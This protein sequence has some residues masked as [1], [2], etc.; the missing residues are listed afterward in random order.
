MRGVPQFIED[1]FPF[2]VVLFVFASCAT[3]SGL[4]I[5]ARPGEREGRVLTVATF[6][7]VHF[8]SYVPLIEKFEREHP[9]LRVELELVESRSLFQRIFA[10][11]MSDIPG[12]DVVEIEIGSVGRFFSGPLEEVGFVDL[13]DRLHESGLYDEFVP[14]KFQAWTSRGR[15]FGLPRDVSPVALIYQNQVFSRAGVDPDSIETWDDFFEAGQRLTQ[16]VD[17]DGVID[18]YAIELSDT[19]AQD[20]HILLLQRGGDFFLPDLQLRLEEE[21]VVDTLAFYLRM[22]AGPRRIGAPLPNQVAANQAVLDGYVLSHL[23]PDWKLGG[24]RHDSPA[25]AGKLRVM[26]L[27]AWERGGRRT[28]TYGGTMMSICKSST[29]QDEAWDFLKLVYTDRDSLLMVYDETLLIPPARSTWDAPI[30]D[31]PIAYLGGQISGR[32]YLGLA[33]DVPP[34]VKT[35][36]SVIAEE[37]VGEV[38]LESCRR[39]RSEG[40]E[41]AHTIAR[42]ELHRI[43][44]RLRKMMKRNPFL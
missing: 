33:P 30:F 41:H 29:L 35:P 22:A 2:G 17:G 14:A 31:A 16:D 9:G 43:A 10:S 27:P 24:F 25:M 7:Q 3:L 40:I 6:A 37:L 18:H 42:E 26:P 39:V 36:F 34:R 38:V 15:I 21:I 8:E 23:S 4:I 13:T 1:R 11:F 32:V 20:F 19:R 12:P 28:S 44:V 5:S